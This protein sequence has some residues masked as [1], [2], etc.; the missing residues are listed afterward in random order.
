LEKEAGIL[1][2]AG[3][4]CSPLGHQTLGSF[5]NGGVTRFSFGYYN[6]ASET[7]L[8]LAALDRLAASRS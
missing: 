4:Q 3:L 5:Q 6:T 1:T 8:A 2:R 7:D